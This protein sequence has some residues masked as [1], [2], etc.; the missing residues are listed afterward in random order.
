MVSTDFPAL[1]GYRDL[2]KVAESAA[3]FASQIQAL[4]EQKYHKALL[5][6]IRQ[7]RVQ[8]ES[9]GQRAQSLKQLLQAL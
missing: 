2:I 1:D 9:W 5:R 4:S 6:E 3:G 7:Q 8:R